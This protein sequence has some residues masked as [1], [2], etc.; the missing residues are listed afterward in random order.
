L[1]AILRHLELVLSGVGIVVIFAVP[2]LFFH[3]TGFHGA[4]L[5]WQA[6]A[7]TAAA[8]GLIHGLI[9]YLVRRRQ[10]LVRQETIRE[11]QVVVD[12]IV[13]NQ[14]TVIGLSAALSRESNRTDGRLEDWAERSINAAHEIGHRL[15]AIDSER[16]Q[17]LIRRSGAGQPHH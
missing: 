6:A 7:V 4:D 13:R 16:L 5:R 15:K 11:M 1:N 17:H 9:F 2:M 14:L 3:R 12:D 8:V 10:R